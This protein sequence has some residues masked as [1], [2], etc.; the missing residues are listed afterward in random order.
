MRLFFILVGGILAQQ[1]LAADINKK[2]I[3][4]LDPVAPGSASYDEQHNDI[5][6]SKFGGNVDFN[7]GGIIATGPEF[8][9]GNFVKNGYK[10]S[11]P[12]YRREDMFPGERHKLDAVRLR[13]MITKWEMPASMRGWYVKAGYSYLRINSRANRYSE[14]Y[15]GNDAIPNNTFSDN[16][17]EETDLIT[18]I[19]HGIATGFGN[20]WLFFNQAL[21]LTLGTSF[22]SNF[23]RTIATDSKD[24]MAKRD[25]ETFIEELPD[26]KMSLRPSPEINLSVG[27]AW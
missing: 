2:I 14:I 3:T 9:T 25:Y 7:V 18:D 1:S 5:A 11:E 22:T 16:P 17:S 19:R 10:G 23:K 4:E 6:T 20:R 21:S 12:T 8:W 26:T 24:Q 15:T 13:W 27:Y